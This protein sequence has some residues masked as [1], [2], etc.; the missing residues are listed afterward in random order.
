LASGRWDPDLLAVYGVPL[1][2]L[3]RL[4]SSWGRVD[5]LDNGLV[6]TASVA[7][8]AASALGA[9]NPDGRTV[10]ANF[11]TGA[12]VLWPGVSAD[13]RLRGYLTAPLGGTNGDVLHVLEGTING[14][15][16]SLDAC[17]PGPTALPF[18]DTAPD[19]FALPDRAGI[20]APHWL[21]DIG[22][23]MSDPALRLSSADRRRVML[24]GLLFRV[25][26]IL[27]DLGRGSPPDRV[28][29]AGGLT[30]D[31]A[32]AQGLAALL[33][34]PVDLL[35]EPQAG[36]LAVARLAAGLAPNAGPA[37]GRVRPGR[38]GAYLPAKYPRWREWLSAALAQAS[39]A[40]DSPQCGQ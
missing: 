31:P 29:L 2:A 39:V 8:Q 25:R 27:D 16:P 37:S 11:G 18:A 21:A 13:T 38:A 32:L 22:P 15:G 40:R 33:G 4:E 20:G 3:P 23:L 28:L 10:L 5:P 17:A 14:A 36:L 19:A 6:L 26:E 34:R 1:S 35:T 30:Q 24:E 12:F 7:D 9:M